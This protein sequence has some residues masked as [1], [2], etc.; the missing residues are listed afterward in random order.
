MPYVSIRITSDGVTSD[1]KS[2]V[3]A[4][5]TDALVEV[6]GKDPAGCHVVIDEVPLENWGYAGQSVRER[7][8]GAT[9][10]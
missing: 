6:L 9:E 8:R 5:V 2:Q 4:R 1:Q 3:I 7:R 10:G